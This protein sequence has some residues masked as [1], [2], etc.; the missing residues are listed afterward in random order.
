MFKAPGT[1]KPFYPEGA[2]KITELNPPCIL[3]HYYSDIKI[4]VMAA[5]KDKF[6]LSKD[7]D[8]GTPS[9]T[10]GLYEISQKYTHAKKEV[11]KTVNRKPSIPW[12]KHLWQETK[13]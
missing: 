12:T 11:N 1:D 8:F 2:D 5:Y 3:Q 6:I 10:W 9:H 4:E 7:D 13:W